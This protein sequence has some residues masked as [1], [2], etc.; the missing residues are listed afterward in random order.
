MK[1]SRPVYL[2]LT[3]IRFPISAIASILHR[4]SGVLIFL[5]LGYLL[6]VLGVSTS[7]A[8]GFARVKNMLTEPLHSTL[9]WAILT[10]L[11][12]HLIAGVRHL[13]MDLH[14]GESLAAGRYSAT[15]SIV[16][17]TALSV[18]IGVWLWL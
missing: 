18:L 5:G 16:I 8:D 11:G 6:Y 10:A 2:D 12:Y 1:S 15:A 9:L 7:S 13:L 14:I 17:G 4:L 3:K